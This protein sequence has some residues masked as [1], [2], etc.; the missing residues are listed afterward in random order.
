MIEA[1]AKGCEIHLAKFLSRKRPQLN[2]RSQW[3]ASEFRFGLA[4][5]VGRI[6]DLLFN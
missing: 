2:Q 4:L 3:N 5:R 1:L 6:A